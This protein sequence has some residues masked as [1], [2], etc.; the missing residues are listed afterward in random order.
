[1]HA[2]ISSRLPASEA[3]LLVRTSNQARL[4]VSGPACIAG[5]K[6]KREG[7]QITL[8]PSQ[9]KLYLLRLCLIKYTF[10][11]F[12]CILS[13]SC[14]NIGQINPF[15]I[16]KISKNIWGSSLIYLWALQALFY[17]FLC[18]LYFFYYVLNLWTINIKCKICCSMF[19][20][21]PSKKDK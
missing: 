17:F 5:S 14:F 9:S 2:W 8:R 6:K 7:K 3:G 15:S 10:I 12:S 1:V 18:V 21:F 11:F 13:P 20:L 16:S 4:D 19:L